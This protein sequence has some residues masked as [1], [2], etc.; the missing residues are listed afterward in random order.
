MNRSEVRS[1]VR[2]FAAV[3]AALDQMN[4]PV[5]AARAHALFAEVMAKLEQRRRRRQRARRIM[6]AL[7]AVLAA[8][9][10]GAYRILAP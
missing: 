10:A 2:G 6:R 4:E 1:T 7:G 9:G 5:E 3:R 8:T